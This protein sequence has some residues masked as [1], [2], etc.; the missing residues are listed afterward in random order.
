MKVIAIDDESIALSIIENF[1]SRIPFLSYQGGYI[2]PY[3]AWARIQKES[4][5]LIFLDIKMPDINGIEWARSLSNSP[6]II[7]STA[8]SEHALESFEV[9][10]VDYLLKPYSFE[11][12]QRAVTKAHELFQLKLRDQKPD[13]LIKSG[14]EHLKINTAEILFIQSAGNYVQFVLKT[15]KVT[16]RL[17][18]LETEKILPVGQFTRIHRSYIVSISAISGFDRQSVFI[19]EK[20]IP[21]GPEYASN[22]SHL[23]K[24]G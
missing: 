23:F 2:S 4:I 24:T 6:L 15:K 20:Q 1:C 8:Y 13:I 3:E 17:T 7:F 16:S 5:D 11:R 10:P 21:V 18:L 14:N 12:F 9:Q 19:D 22:L